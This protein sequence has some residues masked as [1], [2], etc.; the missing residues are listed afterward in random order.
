M[1]KNEK[2]AKNKKGLSRRDFLKVTGAATFAGTL[3]EGMQIIGPSV[4]Q[5]AGTP[6]KTICPYCSV[7]CGMTVVPNDAGTDVIDIYGDPDSVISRGALCS[8][9]SAAIELVRS[10][11]RIG[12]ADSVVAT[13]PMRRDGDGAWVADSWDNAMADIA[14][15]MVTARGTV[16]AANDFNSKSVAFFGCSH[17]TNEE[18]YLYRKLIANFGTNN[19]EH[20]ARI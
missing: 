20:Q 9:G 15:K 5:A 2:S 6:V 8:K 7:G 10:T 11:Q 17:G 13:G 3:V 12:T 18:N 14:A 16:S 1:R 4:A 19:T